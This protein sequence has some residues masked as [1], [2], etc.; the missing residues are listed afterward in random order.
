MVVP[1][2]NPVVATAGVPKVGP[3]LEG[4]G[5][6]LPKP[7]PGVAVVVPKFKAA[8]G[9]AEVVLNDKPVVFGAG[10]PKFNPGV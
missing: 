8:V 4:T 6:V 2:E 5:A 9:G 7:N 3:P 1:K 10:A